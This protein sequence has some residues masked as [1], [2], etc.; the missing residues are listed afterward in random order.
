M[1]DNIV[2]LAKQ[3]ASKIEGW[4]EKDWEKDIQDPGVSGF[5]IDFYNL[6]IADHEASKVVDTQPV[7]FYSK[8]CGFEVL[9]NI[10]NAA[11][12]SA[13]QLASVQKKA[14]TAALE[15]NALIN[16]L[17]D[18]KEQLASVQR[19][20]DELL[21]L[22]DV[23][24]SEYEDGIPCHEEPDGIGGYIGNAMRLDDATFK[25]ISDILN[26]HRPRK[27]IAKMEKPE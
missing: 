3:L 10:D 27:A 13:E 18:Y 22:L 7:G 21:D 2:A 8:L 25:R 4:T 6:A 23:M 17:E 5:F 16:T 1:K 24:F 20:R 19:E 9:A 11:L 14:N 12:Y 26:K 15:I